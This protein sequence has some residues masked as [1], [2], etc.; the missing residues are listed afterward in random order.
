MA[1]RVEMGSNN[2]AQ[3]YHFQGSESYGKEVFANRYFAKKLCYTNFETW[4]NSG[5]EM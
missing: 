1:A 3:N 5:K 4:P 2:S